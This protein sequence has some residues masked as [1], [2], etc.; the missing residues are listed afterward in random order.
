M[1][2]VFL[3]LVGPA[4]GARSGSR[5]VDQGRLAAALASERAKVGAPGAQATVVACNRVAWAG[6]S[7]V[8]V[9]GSKLSE[10]Q[11]TPETPFVIASPTKT[12]TAT[13]IMLEEQAGKLSLDT[14]LSDYNL[15]LPELPSA[16]AEKITVKML[17]SNRSGLADYDISGFGARHDWKRQDILDAIKKKDP[18]GTP[19]YVNSNWVIL[20]GI[21]EKVSNEPIEAFFRNKI[22]K[23]A[24]MTS[25]STFVR[26]Q[27]IVG[28]MAHPYERGANGELTTS[29]INDFGLPTSYWGPVFTDGGLVSTATDLARFGHALISGKIVSKKTLGVMTDVGPDNY[30]LGISSREF[31]GHRWLGHDGSYGGYE[32]ENW[33]DEQRQVT[34]AVT[35]NMAYEKNIEPG[36][37]KR[38]WR[39]VVRAYDSQPSPASC[40]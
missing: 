4:A 13:M 29:W 5:N 12:V 27:E 10:D 3:A 15:K 16:D 9:N 19:D 24:D 22:A 38:I 21:L 18:P 35:T 2:L 33:T 36:V 40:S 17:L 39:E 23:P 31:N 32:S 25:T 30:G 11:V 14:P 6:A 7:G 8:T 26:H 20:G 28:K 37:A 1:T 34:I